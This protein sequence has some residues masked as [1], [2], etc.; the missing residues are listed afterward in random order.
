MVE[1][2]P[3]RPGSGPIITG[4]TATGFR[5]EGVEGPARRIDGALILTP[6]SALPWDAPAIAALHPDKLEPILGLAPRPEF[7]LLGTGPALVHPPRDFIAAME[8]MEI[9]VEPMDSRAAARAWGVLRAEERW[10]AA[11]IMAI[12]DQPSSAR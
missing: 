12:A 6:R 3:D 10:I 11:A 7:I 2:R 1:L 5:L 4:I 8:A 9:G